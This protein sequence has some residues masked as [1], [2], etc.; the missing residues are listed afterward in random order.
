MFI[1]H[2]GAGSFGEFGPG[3]TWECLHELEGWVEEL[4]GIGVEN[5][6]EPEWS[7]EDRWS[8]EDCRGV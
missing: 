7:P 6:S 4:L 8:D 5:Y 2:D 1:G 3:S